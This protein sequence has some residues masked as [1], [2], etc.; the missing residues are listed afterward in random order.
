MTTIH[1]DEE[2]W[3]GRVPV[4]RSIVYVLGGQEDDHVEAAAARAAR[5]FAV[6]RGFSK[7]CITFPPQ[8]GTTL[9]VV[10]RPSGALPEPERPLVPADAAMWGAA[11]TLGNECTG[12]V[13][14]VSWERSG[15]I[16]AD[17][18]RL[19]LELLV[20]STEDEVALTTAGRFVPRQIEQSRP[21]RMVGRHQ[22]PY[23]LEL[24]HPGLHH[25]LAWVEAGPVTPA[26][27]EVVI[28]VR[29]AALNYHDVMIAMGMLPAD[30]EEDLLDGKPSVGFECA[31]VVTAIG[32]DVTALRPGDRVCGIAPRAFASHVVSKADVMVEMPDGMD[33]AHAA[34]LPVAFLTVHHSLE[35]LA[36]LTEGETV[37]V[38]GA[39]GGVGLAAIQ[40][41]QLVG[42]RVIATAGTPAKR[43]LLSMLGVEHVLDSRSLAFADQ[44]MALTGGAGVDVVLN[45]LSG[46]AIPRGL[47]LL[48]PH[49]RF[50]ELGKRDIYANSRIMLRA[51]RNNISLFC[52]DV[53]QVIATNPL[54]ARPQVRAIVR[55]VA[56]GEYRPLLHRTYP[57][58]RITEAFR[59]M[60]HSRHIGKVV[61]TFDDPVPVERNPAPLRLDPQGTYLITGGLSGL[62]AAMARGPGPEGCSAPGVGRPAGFGV[63]RGRGA[64]RKPGRR[65]GRGARVR[66][67][68]RRPR[69]DVGGR[70]VDRRL[71]PLVAGRASLRHAAG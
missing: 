37:L 39:A 63:A 42:A 56:A 9:W 46:E 66:S 61:V 1:G 50:V 59:L 17:A 49:G 58:G 47:E 11:R 44:I 67:R 52:V 55:R 16:E 15:N 54:V 10:T 60:Q 26:A 41:A 51:F 22:Q 57:A 40:H 45:S 20:P 53:A 6:L 38:H 69:R 4:G 21:L 23:Q 68:R 71:G 33:F 18:D 24:R 29:A 25:E 32:T 64:H 70:G 28:E 3:A 2:E 65:G 14:R 62:G 7:A 36:R 27:D 8:H 30:T 48:R 19:A 13:R 34:T 5:R 43:D 35:H 12:V 31:G